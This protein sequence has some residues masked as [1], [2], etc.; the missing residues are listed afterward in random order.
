MHIPP[1]A[2]Q[3]F[4]SPVVLSSQPSHPQFFVSHCQ[5]KT[6]DHHLR[7]TYFD[8]RLFGLENLIE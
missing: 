8:R 5:E 3:F 1:S 2:L 4:P 6:R 7:E